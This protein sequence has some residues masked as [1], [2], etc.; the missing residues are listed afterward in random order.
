MPTPLP[1][2]YHLHFPDGLIGCPDWQHFTVERKPEIVPMLLLWSDDQPGLSLPVVNPWL[3][4]DGYAPQL[5]E[6]ER[7][8][9]GLIEGDEVDWLC[10]LNVQPDGVITAN[11]LGPIAF[12][13]RTGR[14]V[15]VIQAQ[16]GY[17]AAVLLG[18]AQ[19][20]VAHVG[21]DA[22]A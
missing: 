15:Q 3:V 22:T 21:A 13:R 7:T 11:L 10:V 18:Q 12:N 1:T 4:E 8:A 17:S 16:A 5:A 19:A 6:A 2:D 9:L 20:E 14:A